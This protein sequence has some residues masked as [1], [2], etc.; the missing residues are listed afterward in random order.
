MGIVAV[1]TARGIHAFHDVCPHAGWK[2]SDGLVVDG[3]LE[4][5]GHG[6]QYEL[7]TGR[8]Q[9]VPAHCLKS[10]SVTIQDD[11]VRFEWAEEEVPLVRVRSRH[12]QAT[13]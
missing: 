5:P 9:D 3:L 10:V 11:A 7:G 12:G 2:L 4:C 6:W 8:C 13:A 1:R